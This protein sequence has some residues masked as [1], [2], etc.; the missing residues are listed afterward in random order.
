MMK[1]GK[2]AP[3]PVDLKNRP[4]ITQV[5][6][7]LDDGKEEILLQEQ[8]S[9]GEPSQS[10]FFGMRRDGSFEITL[11]LDWTDLDDEHGDPMLDADIYHNGKKYRVHQEKWHH[12]RKAFE[13]G[14]WVYCFEFENIKLRFKVGITSQRNLQGKARIAAPP[15]PSVDGIRAEHPHAPWAFGEKQV[16]CAAC[17]AVTTQNFVVDHNKEI[18]VTCH[19][20]RHMKFPLTE[21]EEQ[22]DALLAA[23]HKANQRQVRV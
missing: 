5:R 8:N 17:Q 7:I 9:R 1:L 23:H 19:C 6:A 20:G 15:A 18:L 4:D 10:T 22:L 12:T 21:T 14:E 13:S 3:L 11:R 2:G 16:F